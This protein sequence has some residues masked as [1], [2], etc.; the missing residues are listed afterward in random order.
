M[1]KQVMQ[2][3]LHALSMP[4]NRWNKTQTLIVNAAIADLRAAIDAPVEEPVEPV[5]Y[6]VPK[7]EQFCL[8][9]KGGRPFA[10]AWEPLYTTPPDTEGLRRDLEQIGAQNAKLYDDFNKSQLELERVKGERDAMLIACKRALNYANNVGEAEG[11]LFDNDEDIPAI[12]AAIA[13]QE[14][15]E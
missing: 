15:K 12:E 2:N 11:V 8:A 5:A 10:K 4:C 14:G 13:A 6:W 7:A 9:D 1:S 3:A